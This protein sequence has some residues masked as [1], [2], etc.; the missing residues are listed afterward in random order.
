MSFAQLAHDRFSVRA[1]AP[2]PVEPEKKDALIE[3][4]RVAPTACNYQPVKIRVFETPEDLEKLDLCSPC[5]FGAPLA[6]LMCYDKTVCWQ[7]VPTEDKGSGTMD[8]SIAA[9]HV[10]L[11][12]ADLG[13][14]S[15]WVGMFFEDKLREHF[16]I[17]EHIVPVALVPLGYA[18][19]GC[20]PHQFHTTTKDVSEL[21]F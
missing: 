7:P 12:A 10:L 19:E 5:R 13:L 17:P 16:A 2:T 15:I 8:A 14:G 11:Q 1:F 3:A 20:E 18:A 21:L 6:F 9:T 4:A